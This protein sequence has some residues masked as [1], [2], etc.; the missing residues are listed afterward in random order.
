MELD[1]RLK[2]LRLSAN[3]TQKQLAA[4][5]GISVSTVSSYELG[6]NK[7]PYDILLS[8]ADIFHVTTD[9]ILGRESGGTPAVSLDGLNDKEVKAVQALVNNLRGK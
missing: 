9:F 5:M 6:S 1:T 3:L 7:P 2:S 4:R 8:Y